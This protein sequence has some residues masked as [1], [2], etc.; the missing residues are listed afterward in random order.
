V[1]KVRIM[2]VGAGQRGVGYAAYFECYPSEGE[3]MAVCEPQ[4]RLRHT[5][6]DR[7]SIPEERRFA[8]WREVL[9]K[10]RLADAVFI[11]TQD[12][13]HRDPAVLLADKGYHIMLEKPMAPDLQSCLD[14][15]EAAERNGIILAVC[16]VLR[17]TPFNRKI[18]EMLDKGAIGR[19]RSIQLLEP[20]G[21]WHQAHS[22][23]R[24]NWR[25]EGQS[26]PMLLAKSCH[27]I[28]LI[29]YFM[30]GRCVRVSSFG[31]L[32]YFIGANQPEGAADRCTDCPAEIEGSCAYSA[33]KIYLR[34]RKYSLDKWPVN[35]LTPEAAPGTVLKAL[36]TGPYGRC[37]FACDNDV[38]DHQVVNM[39]FSGGATASFTMSGFTKS[40]SRELLIMGDQGT[41]RCTDQGIDYFDFL[42]DRI[43]NIEV[44]IGDGLITSGHGGGDI[45]LIREFLSAVRSSDPSRVISGPK[46]S[47][48]SHLIVFAAERARRK[49]SVEMVTEKEI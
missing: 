5:F 17:Y 7:F 40:G 23:V 45:G 28:D 29:N 31:D 9:D 27:D 35:V 36:Q 30:P 19:I 3:I 10:P 20:V 43:S 38:V 37:V 32:S 26:T 13:G 18:K 47:L 39:E 2:V 49:G 24:G 46:V 15:H 16:H 8:D 34:D 11:C 14:I 1:N 44:D 25:N 33:L 21:Y 48:E 12:K 41:L 4:D 22:F 42:N 6:G